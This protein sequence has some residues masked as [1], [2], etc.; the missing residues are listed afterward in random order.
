MYGASQLTELTKVKN[1]YLIVTD[2]FLNCLYSLCSL[3]HDH[4][5]VLIMV[6]KNIKTFETT[7][8][9]LAT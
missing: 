2:S 1:S 8:P 5:F 4:S 3:S 9:C 7:L 6:E